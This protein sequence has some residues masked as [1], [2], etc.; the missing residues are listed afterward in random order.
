MLL[1]TINLRNS[2]GRCK[3]GAQNSLP[4]H[5]SM[6][7]L[8]P[9]CCLLHQRRFITQNP[10]FHHSQLR[11]ASCPTHF[12]PPHLPIRYYG[13][14]NRLYTVNFTHTSTPRL[15]TTAIRLETQGQRSKNTHEGRGQLKCDDTRAETRFRLSAKR[16][17]PFKPAGGVSSVHYW[18]PRCAHQR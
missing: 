16:T 3:N 11:P 9:L 17:S 6:S 14:Q 15:T 13:T 7:H 12:T 2:K 1:R 4:Y 8:S 10:T 18:Q 5:L